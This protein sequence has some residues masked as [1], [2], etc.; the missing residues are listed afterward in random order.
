MSSNSYVKYS[1]LESNSSINVLEA[2]KRS[3]K[4]KRLFKKVLLILG[5]VTGTS[6]LNLCIVFIVC[7][8]RGLRN[9]VAYSNG[10]FY[11]GIGYMVFSASMMVTNGTSFHNIGYMRNF[12]VTSK[13]FSN[14]AIESIQGTFSAFRLWAVLFVI[15]VITCGLS[16]IF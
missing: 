15:G 9:S 16:S 6:L 14:K 2:I 10:L 13:N 3:I 5:A 4:M 11:M 8:S 1:F 7:W 12:S